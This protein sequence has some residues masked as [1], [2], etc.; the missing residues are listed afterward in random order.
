[1]S[2][3]STTSATIDL[4]ALQRYSSTDNNKSINCRFSF[5]VNSFEF[6]AIKHLICGNCT[7][8]ESDGLI[9]SN[10]LTSICK[11]VAQ[12]ARI[13]GYLVPFS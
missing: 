9:P 10:S 3:S 12:L 8:S 2:P 1:M 7:E 5:I 11:A 4:F 6:R 13:L